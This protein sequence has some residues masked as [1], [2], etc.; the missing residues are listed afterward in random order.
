MFPI[1]KNLK[2]RIA[3]FFLTLSACVLTL[4]SWHA[5]AADDLSSPADAQPDR[6]TVTVLDETGAPVIQAGVMVVST[7][8]GGVTDL[9][10]QAFVYARVGDVLEITFIGYETRRVTVPPSLT[11][12]VRLVPSAE[13]IEET[14]IVGYGTQKRKSVVAA[15]A[16]VSNETLR[17]TG[18]TPDLTQALIGQVPGLVALTASGEPGGILTGESATSLYIRG[19]NTWNGGGPLILVDGVERNMNNIEVNEVENISILKDASATAVFG[20]KGANGVILITTKRGSEGK[21]RLSFNYNLTGKMLAKQPGKLDSYDAMMA[22]NAIIEREGVLNEQSWNDYVPYRII[23]RFRTQGPTELDKLMYPGIDWDKEAFNY[24]EIY[25]NVSWV[26]EMFKKIALNTHRVSVNLQGGSKRFKYFSSLAYIHE[27]DMFRD[28]DNGKPYDPNYN[29]DRFNFRSNIDFDLTKTTRLKFDI[30]GF[31]SRKNTNFINEG[32]TSRSDQTMWSAAYFFAPN[33]FIPRFADGRWGAYSD[34]TNQS[35]NPVAAVNNVGVRQTRQTQ[36][37]ARFAVEQDLAFITKGLKASFQISYDNTVRSEGGI[38][39]VSNMIRASDAKTNVA[40][41][42]LNYKKYYP[43]ADLSEYELLLPVPEDEF[44]WTYKT[45]SLRYET[46]TPAN[47]SSTIPVTRR[48]VYQAQINYAR[49]FG[50][51]GVTAMGVFKREQYAQGTMFPNYREDWVGRATYDYDSRYLL[52]LNGAYNGSE[53]FGPG[54]RF[55]FFPSVAV[56]WYMSNEPW[57]KIDWLNKTKV[58]YSIGKVGDDSGGSRW[59]YSSSFAYGGYARLAENTTGASPYRFY[60]E[61]TLGNPHLHW[62][63]ATKQNLG[64]ELS[65]WKDLITLSLDYYTEKRRDI[66]IGGSSRSVPDFL[67]ISPPASNLGKVNSWGF[68]VELGVNKRIG[69][70]LLLWSKLTVAH[71]EN[72]II[73]RDDPALREDYLKL[74]GYPVGQVRRQISSGMYTSWDEIYA[75]VP[76]ETNDGQKLPGYFNIVDFNADGVIKS[77]DD[78][79]PWGYSS[80]PQNTGS[81]DLG[82]DWKGFSFMIQFYAV[83]NVNRAIAWDNYRSNYDVV[84]DHVKDYWSKENPTGQSFLPRW[85]TQGEFIGDFFNYDASYVRL[86][87]VELSYKFKVTGLL[88]K[89]RCDNLRIFANGNDLFFWSDIPDA[90][91]SVYSG[92]NAVNG[93]YPTLRRVNFGIDLS[94]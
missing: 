1:K 33:L 66:I 30:G 76:Q 88:K 21:T 75:S 61:S 31:F 73:F 86:K 18:N 4:P 81:I 44:D 11:V 34:G 43:G 35:I 58:R 79:A 90:R 71:N 37:N 2:K 13:S 91:E 70:D 17:R 3:A 68:E 77:A 6:V 26:D 38:Y 62:E 22:K 69:K 12:T 60:R 67:G 65:G 64:I 93:T 74:A 72:T 29:F 51:H 50:K 20:V 5:S 19:Q 48:M 23:E 9:D 87:T 85:Q 16:Q 63:T 40:F 84:F 42:Y 49:D 41:R 28:Y 47:W 59:A 39:D 57:F 82:V 45:P 25:P 10:G 78:Q 80:I 94:F 53:K 52:E 55:D 24:S 8:T 54:Y 36:I 46:I 32:S 15:V 27:G 7:R 92:G 14:V 89:I 83:N 56:G